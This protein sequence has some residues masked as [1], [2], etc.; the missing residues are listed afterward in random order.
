MIT[1]N[2]PLDEAERIFAL[3]EYGILDTLPEKEFDDITKIASQICG[4]T[5]SLISL[6]DEKRQWFKS[7]HGVEASE[8][9]RDVAFCAHAINDKNHPLIVP[10][11][12]NDER[13]FDNPLVTGDPHV[14]FYTGVPLVSPEG[15]A[16]GTLCVIDDK[17]KTLTNSQ[18][19][20]LE[21][22]GNQVV[23][24]FEHRKKNLQ[25]NKLQL[26][27]TERNTN[28]DRFARVVSHDIKSPLANISSF[29]QLLKMN[30]SN[31]LDKDGLE[32]VEFINQSA[33]QLRDFVDGLL[34]Y[35]RSD[36][37]AFHAKDTIDFTAFMASIIRLLELPKVICN[38][39]YPKDSKILHASEMALKQIFINLIS[40]AIKYNYRDTI[41][42]DIQV[43]EDSLFYHFSV[44][45]NGI[46]IEKE[47]QEKI[48]ELFKHLDNKDRF[49]NYGT[50]IGL[51]T[52]KRIIEQHG[53]KISL[54]SEIDKGSTFYFSYLKAR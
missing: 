1:P 40:N 39:T 6:I 43:S 37:A 48:F 53:G 32:C 20:S 30:H 35:Y 47:H 49:G 54:I 25:L 8:A 50:G 34:S 44:S 28:L 26:Y 2:I 45:D 19:E 3:E 27:L 17:P 42:I 36:Q 23:R 13:F 33:N 11:S 7:H 9:P 51:A 16:L 22:L 24:L 12:R 5:I 31:Q 18:L 29:T 38:I 15:F 14:I 10:D 4:T 21:A 46:G 41:D 52:V